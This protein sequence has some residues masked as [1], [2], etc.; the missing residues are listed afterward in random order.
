MGRK[1]TRLAEA[2]ARKRKR[3]RNVK[4]V[5]AAARYS[6]FI[7]VLSDAAA[8]G[9]LFLSFISLVSRKGLTQRGTLE[10]QLTPIRLRWGVLSGTLRSR[11]ASRSSLRNAPLLG[12]RSDWTPA[13]PLSG[14]EAHG[15]PSPGLL[16]AYR[17]RRP[18]PEGSGRGQRRP[19][20]ALRYA[21]FS[22]FT[23][24]FALNTRR[25]TEAR[26]GTGR[27]IR[28]PFV[29]SRVGSSTGTWDVAPLD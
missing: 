8:T 13:A 14:H 15:G 21:V 26:Q 25:K 22:P 17:T 7:F 6:S 24:F 10:S 12:A 2:K 16:W 3:E 20:L 18:L 4:E 5:L 23:F 19:E 28:L 9:R 1:P 29:S 11:R 27:K